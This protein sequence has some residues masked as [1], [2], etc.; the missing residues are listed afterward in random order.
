MGHAKIKT[1]E[2]YLRLAKS[3]EQEVARQYGEG[4]E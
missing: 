4:A 1:A 3:D 2:R